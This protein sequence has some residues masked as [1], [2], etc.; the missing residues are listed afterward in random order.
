MIL[1][2]DN[3]GARLALVILLLRLYRAQPLAPSRP[4]WTRP[5]ITS[6]DQ[7]AGSPRRQL[8]QAIPGLLPSLLGLPRASYAA[9]PVS[10]QETEGARARFLRAVRPKPMRLLRNKLNQEFAVL[11]MRSSYNALDELDCVPMDQFQRDFF[12][13]RQGKG[14]SSVC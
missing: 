3:V 6:S 1:F 11:L 8:L 7:V 14:A 4:S 5:D 13:V 12:L 2:K 10:Q 9:A